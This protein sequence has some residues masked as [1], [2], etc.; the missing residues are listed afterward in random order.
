[1]GTTIIDTVSYEGN[2]GAPYTEG[3]GVGLVDTGGR[4]GWS[5]EASAAVPTARTLT[6]TTST[7]CCGP[8]ARLVERLSGRRPRAD[9]HQHSP[10]N[11]AAGV[12]LA[13]DITITF[14][15]PVNVAGTWYAIDCATTLGHSATVTG[16]ATTFTLD[17][18]ADFAE[19]ESCTVTVTA[20]GVTDQ[21]TNDPPDTMASNHAFTFTVVNIED[22]TDPSTP[23]HAIQGAGPSSPLLGQS[24]SIDGIV[25]GDYQ[26]V[27]DEFG[28][29]YLQ[30]LAA[31]ADAN[32]LTSEGI[33]V[34]DNDFGVAVSPG[35]RV[36]VR[37]SVAEFNGLTEL[38]SVAFVA[39][40]STGNPLPP[41]TP[42]QP[43]GPEGHRP[44]GLRGDARPLRPDADR[45]R[46]LQP[47]PLRRGQP[48]RRRPA[49]HRDRRGGARARA[50]SP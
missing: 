31:E 13:A 3:S 46:G 30:E 33:F 43:A 9:R 49:L 16:D 11:G 36:R 8:R 28:G 7:S 21:D 1:M 44:R 18:T 38:A 42:G 45:D 48:V 50:P 4:A 14:S 37:G 23:I 32:P 2:T 19:G 5:R 34:F 41:A 10:A 27:P 12:P 15:E 29:F 6:R 22:C 35:D 20:A 25:V 26:V 40:C 24:H 17:P 47:R 39:V